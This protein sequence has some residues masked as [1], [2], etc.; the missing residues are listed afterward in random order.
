[1]WHQMSQEVHQRK[2]G[3][4]KWMSGDASVGLCS[5]LIALDDL[6]AA[7]RGGTLDYCDEI[8]DVSPAGEWCVQVS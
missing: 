2:V 4:R 3:N 7:A 1:M 8:L 5:A 6:L